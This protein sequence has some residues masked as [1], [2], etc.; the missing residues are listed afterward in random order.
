M[1]TP[2]D[3]CLVYPTCASTCILFAHFKNKLDNDIKKMARFVYSKNNHPRKRMK[4]QHRKHYNA[5]IDI[6]NKAGQQ[7]DIIYDR[8]FKRFG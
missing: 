4:D 8:H 3:T 7:H 2:C 6:W 5:L 1:K